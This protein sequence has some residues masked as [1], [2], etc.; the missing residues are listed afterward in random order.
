MRSK[1]SRRTK[2]AWSPVAMPVARERTFI[3]LG[4][5]LEQARLA[6]DL[7]VEASPLHLRV[8][9]RRVDR[10]HRVGRQQGIGM[11]E[12]QGRAARACGTEVHLLRA[13]ARAGEHGV[14][15]RTCQ[16]VGAIGAAAIGHDHFHALGSHRAQR[17]QVGHDVRRLVQRRNHDRHSRRHRCGVVGSMGTNDGL[18]RHLTQKAMRARRAAITPQPLEGAAATGRTAAAGQTPFVMRVAVVDRDLFA[19]RDRPPRVELDASI[20]DDQPRV[21]PA[22]VVG[23]AHRVAGAAEVDRFARR[24]LHDH[25]ALVAGGADAR[26][27]HRDAFAADLADLEPRRDRLRRRTRPGRRCG[28][29]PRSRRTSDTP[30]AARSLRKAHGAGGR[31]IRIAGIQ[32]FLRCSAVT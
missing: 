17:A 31:S 2:R 22:A 4:D 5:H 7:H 16:H 18:S 6:F 15:P 8:D 11:Q 12:Q 10:L 3:G 26:L 1:A 25:D 30:A 19:R 9:Q 20:A 32:P 14:R 28:W 23:V 27:G 13:P 29:A 24:H 21:G